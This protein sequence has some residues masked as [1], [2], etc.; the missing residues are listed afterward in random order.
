MKNSGNT[1][2]HF[3]LFPAVLLEATWRPQPG[4]ARTGSHHADRSLWAASSVL[5]LRPGLRRNKANEGDERRRN[6]V[7]CVKI[8]PINVVAGIR[9]LWILQV[10]ITFFLLSLAWETNMASSKVQLF[11]RIP[12]PVCLF[13]FNKSYTL[14]NIVHNALWMS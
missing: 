7:A 13:G 9:F 11:H 14:N 10:M 2:P 3:S 5:Q 4:Q 6:C 1:R 8:S 12:E